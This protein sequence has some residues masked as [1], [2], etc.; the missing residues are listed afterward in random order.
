MYREAFVLR[1]VEEMSVKEVAETIGQSEA[2]TKSRILR[3][4]VALR[5]F[6]SKRF[7]ESYGE[8]V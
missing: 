1:Y 8:Q 7:E 2:A 5:D 4:R 3:A 6:L